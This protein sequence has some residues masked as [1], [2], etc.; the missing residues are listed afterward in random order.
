MF[1][2]SGCLG[3]AAISPLSKSAKQISDSSEGLKKLIRDK[4]TVVF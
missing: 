1:P 4:E 2:T 3:P